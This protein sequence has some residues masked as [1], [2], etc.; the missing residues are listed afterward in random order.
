LLFGGCTA[1]AQHTTPS[2][3]R[4]PIELESGYGPFYPLLSPVRWVDPSDTTDPYYQTFVPLKGLP[5]WKN[6]RIG[7][8]LFDDKQY[9]I[10]NIADGKIN[11]GQS[12]KIKRS[13]HL[14]IDE[15]AYSSIAVKCFVYLVAGKDQ[16][17]IWRV[18]LDENNNL[19]FSDDRSVR[20]APTSFKDSM[21][22]RMGRVL[23]AAE[24]YCKGK[25]IVDTLPVSVMKDS[26]LAPIWYNLPQYAR[27]EVELSGI[28]YQLAVSSHLFTSGSYTDCQIADIT[29]HP[30]L[31]LHTDALIRQG[32][33]I[34]LGIK[35]YRNAGIDICSK[36]L[37]LVE[38]DQ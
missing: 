2:S 6:Q 21:E 32:E 25:I 31:P 4:I 19:D 22:W 7:I 11:T 23:V 24:R 33:I 37:Q 3:L 28:K 15:H 20:P 27:A 34:H 8:I 29:Q 14:S 18:K 1:T 30:A 17:N 9:V 36:M 38:V 13:W 12:E 5:N 35:K 26:G 16:Y 10:Q